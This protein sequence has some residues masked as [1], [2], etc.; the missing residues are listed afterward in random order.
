MGDFPMGIPQVIY[1]WDSRTDD[2][3]AAKKIA[4]KKPMD[5]A[6]LVFLHARCLSSD[7]HCQSSES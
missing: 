6:G 1:W 2:A 3:Y 5:I 7:E 4:Q